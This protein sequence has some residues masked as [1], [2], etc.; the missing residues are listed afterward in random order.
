ML[1]KLI[2]VVVIMVLAVAGFGCRKA[3]TQNAPQKTEVKS[4][5]EYD[6]QAKKE[7]DSNNMQAELDKIEKEVRQE[8]GKRL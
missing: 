3:P 8:S 1:R 6:T 7:I 4:Q 2:A 5:A